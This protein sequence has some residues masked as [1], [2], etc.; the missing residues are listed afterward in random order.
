MVQVTILMMMMMV[1]QTVFYLRNLPI[2]VGLYLQSMMM[3]TILMIMIMLEMMI[4]LIMM[5]MITMM[6]MMRTMITIMILKMI[7]MVS[8]QDLH[9]GGFV[10]AKYRPTHLVK[11]KLTL[12]Q[13]DMWGS[14]NF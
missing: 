14:P 4:M 1:D 12:T 2:R 3:L 5:M 11:L 10:P 7:V 9:V 8:L 6:I 13:I